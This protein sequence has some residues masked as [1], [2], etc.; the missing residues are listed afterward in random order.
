MNTIGQISE[1]N[2]KIGEIF[3]SEWTLSLSKSQAYVRY[4]SGV[5]LVYLGY[6]LGI[7]QA[8]LRHITGVS[9]VYTRHFSSLF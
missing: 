8:Y 7:S 3:I 9:Q 4:I 5:S 2:F 6:I 1:I